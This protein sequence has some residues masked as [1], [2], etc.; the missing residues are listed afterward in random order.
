MNVNTIFLARGLTVVAIENG[1]YHLRRMDERG[2]PAGDVIGLL[3]S[4][5]PLTK[6]SS[7]VKLFL[8][9]VEPSVAPARISYHWQTL[10]ARRFEESGL[11][12]FDVAIEPAQV[13]VPAQ[14]QSYTRPDGVRSR[15]A[16]RLAT[17]EVVCYN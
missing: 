2:Q 17:G 6:E 1:V 12:P 13:L 8:H 15:H 16:T 3:F 11:D 14:D 7:N 4:A 9:D 5:T 10:D